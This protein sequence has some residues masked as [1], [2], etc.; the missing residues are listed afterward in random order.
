[1]S[2][3]EGG[4]LQVWM[5]SYETTRRDHTILQFWPVQTLQIEFLVVADAE[6]REFTS[7]RRNPRGLGWLRRMSP[8]G[9]SKTQTSSMEFL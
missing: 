3:R 1:M 5:M 7:Q 6:V 4:F 9:K 2:V 8:N